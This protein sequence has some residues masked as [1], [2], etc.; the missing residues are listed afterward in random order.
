MPGDRR[1]DP[2]QERLARKQH[3]N[4]QVALAR[5]AL[6]REGKGFDSRGIYRNRERSPKELKNPN[7]DEPP[8]GLS[9]QEKKLWWKQK[10][11]DKQQKM[12]S[13]GFGRF[14]WWTLT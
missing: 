6:A 9:K 7:D 12:F 14:L 2:R 10:K 3:Q 11:K 4:H 5:E 8:P 1:K 13:K